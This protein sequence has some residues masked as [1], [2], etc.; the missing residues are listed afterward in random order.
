MMGED[1][2]RDRDPSGHGGTGAEAGD[3]GLGDPPALGG[4]S[5]N[6]RMWEMLQN[7]NLQTAQKW[8][9]EPQI[10]KMRVQKLW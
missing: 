9:F 2:D 7:P 3:P 5:R 4:F 1:R 10:L 8:G 6:H